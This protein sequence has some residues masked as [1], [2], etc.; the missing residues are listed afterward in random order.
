MLILLT[1]MRVAPMMRHACFFLLPLL[2]LGCGF[3]D[4]AGALAYPGSAGL[5]APGMLWWGLGSLALGLGFKLRAGGR[6]RLG[7]LLTVSGFLGILAGYLGTGAAPGF[8]GVRIAAIIH[9]AIHRLGAGRTAAGGIAELLLLLPLI[10][11][12]LNLAAMVLK[13]E[14]W[15]GVLSRIALYQL[16][17]LLVLRGAS[18]FIE[19]PAAGAIGTLTLSLTALLSFHLAAR[20]GVPLLSQA[21]RDEMPVSGKPYRTFLPHLILVIFSGALIFLS[22]TRFDQVYP[23]WFALVPLLWVTQQ[24][25]NGRAFLWGWITGLIANFG[26]FYWII[27]NLNVYGHIPW[28]LSFLIFLLVSMYNG[29]VFALFAY[30]TR[31]ITRRTGYSTILVAPVVMISL[32]F[33][34]WMIFPWFLAIT[35]YRFLPI[36]QLA[37]LTGVMG[38]SFLLVLSSGAV[39]EALSAWRDRRPI[40]RR[41]LG[42]VAAVLL[43]CYGY[44]LYKIHA[45]DGEREKAPQ[46]KVA[47]IQGGL[48]MSPGKPQWRRKYHHYLK[49]TWEAEKAKPD[50]L[51]WPESAYPLDIH[52]LETNVKDREKIRW[53]STRYFPVMLRINTPLIFGA[54]SIYPEKGRSYNTAH[55]ADGQGNIIGRYDKNYLMLFSEYVPYI[56][57]MPWLRKL[58]PTAPDFIPGKEPKTFPISLRGQS[59]RLGMLIC[60]EDIIPQ[61]ALK[62]SAKKPHLFVNITN[63][64][65]FGKTSEPHQ[66]LAL[67]VFR[68]VEH[69]RDMVRSV[70]VGV[71]CFIDATGRVR[72]SSKI[73]TKRILIDK[74]ALLQGETVFSIVGNLFCYLVLAALLFFLIQTTRRWWTERAGKR[75]ARKG[76]SP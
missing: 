59:F 8:E 46:L 38:V 2:L 18:Q 30:L 34:F 32:E 9:D 41:S 11:A 33:L 13:K 14:R 19:S 24:K 22:T 16:P 25:S 6:A 1:V 39:Y 67:A 62:L 43:A 64:A 70:N 71:S 15:Q 37:D 51:V 72:K 47:L 21:G 36:I 58:L 42:A 20:H 28:F 61:F 3:A 57:K 27:I 54:Q 60:Y 76:S 73:Y 23:A 52:R 48:G 12:L 63:D 10:G 55:Y 26:G 5:I 68:T 4:A 49:M 75:D 17:V 45:V 56:D 31:K 29:L 35:Q 7:L 53:Q 50:L 74:A 65:W 69:R 44:G 66:H 40:P